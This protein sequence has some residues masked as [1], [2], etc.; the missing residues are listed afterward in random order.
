MPS[1]VV[2][3]PRSADGTLIYGEGVGNPRN[4]HVVFIHEATLCSSV[5]DQLFQDVRLTEHLYLVSLPYD[6]TSI[7]VHP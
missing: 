2:K 6:Q 7:S 3:T 1:A 4:P 5:F